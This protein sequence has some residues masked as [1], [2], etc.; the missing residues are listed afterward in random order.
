M[1]QI[2]AH[3]AYLTVYA[4]G[5]FFDK[6]DRYLC[7]KTGISLDTA[8]PILLN[9]AENILEQNLVGAISVE[10]ITKEAYKEAL[11]NGKDCRLIKNDSHFID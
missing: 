10:Y 7:Y 11:E 1:K 8:M 9:T 4:K 3:T 5:T 2:P 6:P